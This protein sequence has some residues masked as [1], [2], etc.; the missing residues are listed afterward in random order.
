MHLLIMVATALA[1]TSFSNLA[2]LVRQRSL[3]M[4]SLLFLLSVRPHAVSGPEARWATP[5]GNARQAALHSG[6]PRT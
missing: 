2:I 6:G 5:E 3:L 4:P 1:Y